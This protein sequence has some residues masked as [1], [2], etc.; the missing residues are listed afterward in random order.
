MNKSNNNFVNRNNN[1]NEN[2]KPWNGGNFNLYGLDTDEDLVAVVPPGQNN[3]NCA[4][5][6]YSRNNSP[7]PPTEI[8]INQATSSYQQQPLANHI[9]M[10]QHS[11]IQSLS[12]S[13]A[14]TVIPAFPSY[15]AIPVSTFAEVDGR[16]NWNSLQRQQQ[17]VLDKTKPQFSKYKFSVIVY[18][19]YKGSRY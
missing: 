7:L 11:Q 5:E 13:A 15:T 16:K 9:A 12:S 6:E 1:N 4:N 8:R 17:G 19:T 3:R 2:S 18:K 14:T 10:S